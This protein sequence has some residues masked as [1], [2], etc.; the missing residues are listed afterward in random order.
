MT[1]VQATCVIWCCTGFSSKKWVCLCMCY[2]ILHLSIRKLTI[3]PPNCSQK[4]NFLRFLWSLFYDLL[5]NYLK[6]R[7]TMIFMDY[8]PHT[9]FF[10]PKT[11]RT[12]LKDFRGSYNECLIESEFQSIIVKELLV[13]SIY[14]LF[15]FKSFFCKKYSLWVPSGFSAINLKINKYFTN[16]IKKLRGG[17]L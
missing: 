16:H 15:F 11:F 6:Y 7:A 1:F 14:L 8:I 9:K 17:V 13:F 12:K 2:L 10:W 5:Q 3:L 4:P